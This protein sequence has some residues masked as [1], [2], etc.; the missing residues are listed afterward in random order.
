MLVLL[1]IRATSTTICATRHAHLAT[2]CNLWPATYNSRAHFYWDLVQP[3][4]VLYSFS[5]ELE[6]QSPSDGQLSCPL[7]R[8]SLTP[9]PICEACGLSFLSLVSVKYCCR[10]SQPCTRSRAR[11]LWELDHSNSRLAARTQTCTS[12]SSLTGT[13]GLRLLAG[14]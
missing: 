11:V 12:D 8:S 10:H 3:S 2:H 4:D 6:S 13:L 7:S 14:F 9:S 5:V 1:C